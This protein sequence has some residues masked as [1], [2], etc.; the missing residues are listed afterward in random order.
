MGFK[1]VLKFG[2]TFVTSPPFRLFNAAGRVFFVS[3]NNRMMQIILALKKLFPCSITP[4]VY[5]NDGAGMDAPDPVTFGYGAFASSVTGSGSPM[6]AGTYGFRE[7]FKRGSTGEV[8]DLGGA[9][10]QVVAAGEY[11]IV[12]SSAVC[13]DEFFFESYGTGITHRQ[14]FVEYPDAPGVYFFWQEVP[15]TFSP[16][17]P[18]ADTAPPFGLAFVDVAARQQAPAAGE[19]GLFPAV[20]SGTFAYGAFLGAGMVSRTPP[21]SSI[22]L[23]AG[24]MI[25]TMGNSSDDDYWS[26]S[27]P[28]RAIVYTGTTQE[29]AGRIY[30]NGET[31]AFVEFIL[32]GAQATLK[33][34]QGIDVTKWPYGTITLTNG[35]STDAPN[36]AFVSRSRTDL[37]R[38]SVFAGEVGGGLSP[39]LNMWSPFN[40]IRDQQNFAIAG[41]VTNIHRVSEQVLIQYERGMSLMSSEFS[42]DMPPRAEFISLSEELGSFNPDAIWADNDRRIYFY[43]QGRFFRLDGSRL[44]DLG[45]I[46]GVSTFM[47]KYV[48]TAAGSPREGR[49]AFNAERNAALVIGLTRVGDSEPY[50]YGALCSFDKTDSMVLSPLSFPTP[51]RSACAVEREVAGVQFNQW[52]LGGSDG[53]YYTH[54]APS[55]NHDTYYTSDDDLVADQ[56]ITMKLRTGIM[57]FDWKAQIDRYGLVIGNGNADFE[58]DVQTDTFKTADLSSTP[59]TTTKTLDQSVIAAELPAA[60]RIAGHAM[61]FTFTCDNVGLKTQIYRLGVFTKPYAAKI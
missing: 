45:Q 18:V 48:G 14:F 19:T 20:S 58:L 2:K 47:R 15:Y 43:A 42:T 10:S 41:K 7:R 40:T 11:V 3:P 56:P 5:Y 59:Q 36:F 4:P 9:I 34:A 37:F 6:V 35:S 33:F 16:S 31:L 60:Y 32:S 12:S 17:L 24:S 39:G 50:R 54:G 25:G 21:N 29:L 51:I 49:V 57:L 28:Y 53:H 13:P 23:T 55:S 44:T 46:A 1:S 52:F 38:S 61:R 22:T 8:S 30:S 26:A 27:D